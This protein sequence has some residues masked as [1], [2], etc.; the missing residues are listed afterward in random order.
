MK[1]LSFI[2]AIESQI[3]TK[4]V[5]DDCAYLKELGIVISQDSLVENIH[6]KR[7]WCSTYQLGYKSMAVNISD[8]LASGAKPKYTTIA[9]SLTNDID[10][11]FVKEFYK[12]AQSVCKNIEIVGGDITG[13]K[14]DIMISIT[15]IGLTKGRNISSR[16]NAKKGYIL[17]TKGN[18]G[19]SALGLEKLQ[20]GKK[21]NEFVKYHLEPELEYEFS[22]QVSTLVKEN[23]AM[24]DT[25]D[26]IVDALFRIAEASGVKLVVDY[27]K[28]PHLKEAKTE[29][30]L[31]G[32][33]DY[34]LVAAVPK[35][36]LTLIKGAVQIGEVCP[37]DG[38]RVEIAG[39][40]YS[41]YDELR[42]YNH[43]GE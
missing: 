36:Y 1:E 5:G 23:Y 2:K 13:S 9:L 42:V 8:I 12:G 35:K 3:G 6:F 34:K 43:F 24:M 40:K 27:D 17:L 38:T 41:S 39:N 19:S 25:S 16:R 26:G 7:D 10:E 14:K 20:E 29:H 33:E 32:G 21:D 15:A 11:N 4:Y 28:I 31:F 18:Y 30:V 22:E 37:F